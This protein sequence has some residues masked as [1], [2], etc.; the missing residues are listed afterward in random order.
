MC[1]NTATLRVSQKGGLLHRRQSLSFQESLSRERDA[2]WIKGVPAAKR[3]TQKFSL[4]CVTPETWHVLVS[5]TWRSN[6]RGNC[7]PR[8]HVSLI[9]FFKSQCVQRMNHMDHCAEII[10]DVF[11]VMRDDVLTQKCQKETRRHAGVPAVSDH[12]LEG[13]R[14]R[15]VP[16]DRLGT[17]TQQRSFDCSLLMKKRWDL[18]PLLN[19]P[20]LS[21]MTKTPATLS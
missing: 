5:S 20:F 10:N 13:A 19:S 7:G 14:N 3:G 21:E 4:S 1:S 17:Q 11:P 15:D 18:I 2:L 8:G 9:S 6:V 12:K 16:H